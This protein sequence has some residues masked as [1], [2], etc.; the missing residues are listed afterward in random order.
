M[1]NGKRNRQKGHDLERYWARFLRTFF[2]YTRTSRQTS[3]ILD[4]CGVDLTGNPFL[5][6]CKAGYEKSY[7]KYNVEYDYI[8]TKLG[9]NFPEGHHYLEAPIIL[10]HKLDGGGPKNPQKHYVSLDFITFQNILTEYYEMNEK[11]KEL[12]I[13]YE[14]TYNNPI[15]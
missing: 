14:V 9:E 10:I 1:S 6:Q 12:G 4:N 11:L 2:P 8:K 5:M 7:P 15:N 13:N 3:L